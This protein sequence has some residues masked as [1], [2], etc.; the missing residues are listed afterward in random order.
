MLLAIVGVATKLRSASTTTIIDVAAP[1]VAIE[2]STPNSA[3][4]R[5]CARFLLPHTPRP[6]THRTVPVAI[7]RVKRLRS[8]PQSP[9]SQP[10]TASGA[11]QSCSFHVNNRVRAMAE[12]MRCSAA[13]V[14]L[15]VDHMRRESATIRTSLQAVNCAAVG[16][17]QNRT[18][19][20]AGT[21]AE[22]GNDAERKQQQSNVVFA[23]D[24]RSHSFNLVLNN[25][26]YKGSRV[27]NNFPLFLANL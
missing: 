21:R 23:F 16:R 1:C 13:I 12:Q 14:L 6:S 25:N 27:V 20:T 10:T 4:R 19:A 9:A 3:S 24:F 26:Y 17:R 2:G 8:D 15:L 7:F 18:F 5:P 22:T 11:L